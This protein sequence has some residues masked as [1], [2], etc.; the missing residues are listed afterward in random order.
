MNKL[1][2]IVG[3][4]GSGKT[5]IS[6]AATAALFNFRHMGFSDPMVAMLHHGFGIPFEVLKDKGQ[7]NDA[8]PELCGRSIRH[9][10]RTLG[11]EWGRECVHPDLWLNATLT[12]AETVMIR[13]NAHVIIDN[14]R[15]PNEL[16]AINDRGGITIAMLRSDIEPDTSH[17]SEQ[18]IDELQERCHY[19]F[20]NDAN[21]ERSI[22][23][24][25]DLLRE[26]TA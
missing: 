1:I 15:F 6:F 24:F 19:K 13:E 21:M 4:M 23:L 14:V 22:E 3:Y 18:Y 16:E 12:K 25:T 5:T 7:W 20:Y 17:A 2:G 10:C 11:A 9:A 8:R 26:V